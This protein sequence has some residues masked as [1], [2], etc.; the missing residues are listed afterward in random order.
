MANNIYRHLWW[1]FMPGT[2]I[3]VTWPMGYTEIDHL[4]TQIL[5]SDPNDHYRPWL[6]KHVGRQH[7]D[8]DWK[9][10]DDQLI[11]KFRIGK[12]DHMMEASLR[13]S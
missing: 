2:K 3:V 7:L 1:R 11:I 8:W 9:I 4:G 13:W 12:K 10:R 5:S 6:E